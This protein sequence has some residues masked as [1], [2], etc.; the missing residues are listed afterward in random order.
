M[1][2]NKLN[3]NESPDEMAPGSSQPRQMTGPLRETSLVYYSIK[4]KCS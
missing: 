2:E 4:N 3:Q 1:T